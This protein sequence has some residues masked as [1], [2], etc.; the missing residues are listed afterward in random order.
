MKMLKFLR[1]SGQPS[2]KRQPPIKQPPE[3]QPELFAFRKV[4]AMFVNMSTS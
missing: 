2:P 4:S 1:G 3:R